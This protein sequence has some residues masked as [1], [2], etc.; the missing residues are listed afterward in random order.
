MIDAHAHLTDKRYQSVEEVVSEFVNEGGELIVDAGYDIRTT[1][2]WLQDYYLSISS[3]NHEP[4]D[5]P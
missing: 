1:A 2:Q 3:T 5:R 4:G